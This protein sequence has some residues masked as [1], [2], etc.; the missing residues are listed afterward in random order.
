MRS[1]GKLSCLR[2]EKE[3]IS[4]WEHCDRMGGVHLNV[5]SPDAF[6]MSLLDSSA[7]LVLTL[8]HSVS[9]VGETILLYYQRGGWFST[10]QYYI[11]CFW[12]SWQW[13]EGKVERV[14]T[15]IVYTVLASR[16]LHG[17]CNIHPIT[18]A[19]WNA[20]ELFWKWPSDVARLNVFLARSFSAKSSIL[21]H[22]LISLPGSWQQ[23]MQLFVW[24]KPPS[25]ENKSNRVHLLWTISRGSGGE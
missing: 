21:W 24:T 4:D 10:L 15:T 7:P 3:L 11:S 25:K 6:F 17:G 13:S 12:N 5:Y 22:N 14:A 16:M 18:V 9:F 23:E 2:N 19:Q 20:M 8:W 1:E